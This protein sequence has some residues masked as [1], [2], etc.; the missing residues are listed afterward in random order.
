MPLISCSY[1][2]LDRFF[3]Q[4]RNWLELMV[5]AN[6]SLH[7]MMERHVL[8]NGALDSSDTE[9]NLA[10]FLYTMSGVRAFRIF[11]LANHFQSMKV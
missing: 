8:P 2:S 9:K 3:R 11:Y 1:I 4:P 7:F 6:S 5:A 10:I